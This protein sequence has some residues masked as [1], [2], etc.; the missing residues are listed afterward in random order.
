MYE[1]TLRMKF[2]ASNF[3]AQISQYHHRKDKKQPYEL[4]FCDKWQ[5]YNPI[6]ISPFSPTKYIC[7][8]LPELVVDCL[9]LPDPNPGHLLENPLPPEELE[10]VDLQ[11]G[12]P[13]VLEAVW[14]LVHLLNN[15]YQSRLRGWGGVGDYVTSGN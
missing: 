9:V 7:L 8:Y 3:C 5:F 4:H 13:D 6:L 11:L 10:A 1:N 15:N 14:G 2:M 12:V